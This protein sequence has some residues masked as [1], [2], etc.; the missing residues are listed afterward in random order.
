M[1]MIMHRTDRDA[2]PAPHA[3]V[4]ELLRQAAGHEISRQFLRFAAV[5]GVATVIHYAILAA[6]VELAHA[7]LIAST[8]A[9]FT[10]GALFSYVTNRRLN[11]ETRPPFTRG[12]AKFFAFGLIGLALNGLILSALHRLGMHYM[13]AQC[14]ATGIVLVY[15]FATARW[16]VFRS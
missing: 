3:R 7:P 14:F 16:I 6:L 15:N 13:L 4:A 2:H 1:R 8:S 11:F 9:G 5:G 10:A 12:L